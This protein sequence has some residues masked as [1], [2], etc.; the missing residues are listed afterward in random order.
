M[1][2][3]LFVS[4]FSDNK[5]KITSPVLGAF[6][7]AWVI[8]N[9]KN[10]LLLF[11]GTGTLEERLTV[12]DNAL[13]FSN[14]NMWLWPLLV[15][16]VYAFGLPY[17]NV[18]SH[19]LRK[20]A[21]EWRHNEVVDIDIVK[22]RKKAK[23]NEEVYKA[24][25]ANPYLGRKLEA[26]LK[27]KEADAERA[28]ADADKAEAERKEALAQ[29]EAAEAEAKKAKA[30]EA[31]IARKEEREH[32]AHELTKA[33]HKQDVANHQFPTL[34]LFLN[35]LSNSLKENEICL[36]LNL[37]SEAIAK[38]FGFED[39]DSMLTDDAF[40][41]SKLEELAC[42]AYDDTQ[43]LSDLKELIKKHPANIDEDELFDYL[44]LMFEEVDKVSF[45]PSSSME[46]IAKDFL[47][48]TGNIF[49]LVHDDAVN[50]QINETSAHS[51][52]PENPEFIDI[53]RNDDGE[54][55]VDA[56]AEINGE[57]ADDRPY[58]GHRIN[59]NF[60]LIYKPIIGRNGFAKPVIEDVSASLN[61]DY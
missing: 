1:I 28:R 27:Q 58:S 53:D 7:G 17:L 29:Q 5:V 48:D 31:E 57:M 42:V 3:E 34:Y 10:F 2:K 18:F 55:V 41:L 46:D 36:P 16:V 14:C 15:A 20:Q 8:F 13:S 44:L 47:D 19:K 51:F 59:T 21:E 54:F 22:A 32:Q 43:L 33:K 45:I 60:Q 11:W 25:P 26:E 23:L 52:G 12:F 50:D 30:K 61:R 6:V 38:C 37:M 39:F 40:T 4:W 9:W 56:A 24:D 35:L 49:D